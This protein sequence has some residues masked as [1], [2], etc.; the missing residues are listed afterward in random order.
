M[1]PLLR[2]RLPMTRPLVSLSRA[3]KSAAQALD[4]AMGAELAPL[5]MER[6][7]FTT[8]VGDADRRPQA[9]IRWIL[10]LQPTPVR[11][12]GHWQKCIWWGAAFPL[13][14]KGVFVRDG[15]QTP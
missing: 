6:A 2:R 14:A 12:R 4:L 9:W 13:G 7:V 10:L 3:R 11:R 8:Q 1:P 15:A 5:K